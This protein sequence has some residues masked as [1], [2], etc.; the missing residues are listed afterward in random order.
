MMTRVPVIQRGWRTLQVAGWR[1]DQI[2]SLHNLYIGNS[3]W[4]IFSLLRAT[5]NSTLLIPSWE[6]TQFGIGEFQG[7]KME[8]KKEEP[9]HGFY[10]FDSRSMK[11]SIRHFFQPLF[12]F[13]MNLVLIT[14]FVY[15]YV[16]SWKIV[17]LL[18]AETF[19]L[20]GNWL[21][22]VIRFMQFNECILFSDFVLVV[23]WEKMRKKNH[24]Y[25]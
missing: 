6:T 20:L 24:K 22:Y 9:L 23:F 1:P 5:I 10:P 4:V 11:S 18:C 15:L 21:H 12:I 14:M 25:S 8:G 19:F 17:L 2:R 16:F 3:T 13:D 7:W